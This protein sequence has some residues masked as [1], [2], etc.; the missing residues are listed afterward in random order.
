MGFPEVER[1]LEE[2]VL[3]SLFESFI[4]QVIVVNL[5]PPCQRDESL[6]DMPN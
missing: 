5:R 4:A 3:K 1:G 2:S 6:S